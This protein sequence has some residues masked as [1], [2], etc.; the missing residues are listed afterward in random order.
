VFVLFGGQWQK[1]TCEKNGGVEI[2][3]T[4]KT[5]GVKRTAHQGK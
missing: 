3:Q 1:D 2:S 4:G 5:Q